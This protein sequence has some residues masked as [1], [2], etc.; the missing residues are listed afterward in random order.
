VVPLAA[1]AALLAI[2]AR[3]SLLRRPYRVLDTALLAWLTVAAAALA[4]LSASLRLAIAPQAA[5]LDRALYI[6]TLAR[7][8]ER[9]TRALS[10]DSDATM[11]AIVM[12]VAILLIFWSAR[13]I[14]GRHGLRATAR[15]LAWT[16]L[17]LSAITLVQHATS[18][19][20]IY[21]YFHP[22][23]RKAAP[24]GPYVNR[25]DLATWLLM[26]IPLVA[27]YGIARVTSR[28]RADGPVDLEESVDATALSLAASVLLMLATVLVS[29]SRSGLTGTVV[30]LAAF[31]WLA[32]RRLGASGWMWVAAILFALLA[33]ATTYA[34][35]GALASRMD[36]TLAV[37]IGG[38]RAV[39]AQTWPMVRD[40]WIS[41][42]GVG[43]FERAMTV[44]QQAPHTFYINHAH[45]EYL[46]LLAE[47]GVLLAVPAALAIGAAGWQA[48]RQLRDDHSPVF[49][50]RAG[51][52]SGMLA[53]AVQGIWDTGLRLPAN[54]VLFALLA[55][56][57]LH[58]GQERRGTALKAS[59]LQNN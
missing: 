44:Y 59:R 15:G 43:A 27:G 56:I 20:L 36:E 5:T 23:A 38:R 22:I 45:N 6:G 33:L 7:P 10:V 40:F 55:A 29:A 3:P 51:A 24:Y 48:I 14:L 11:W 42:V 17:A 32:R 30:G 31:L 12:A 49:W 46:Q 52:A 9:Q 34:N 19:T 28:Q 18:P 57:A 2:A 58:A 47:G 16:G 21:W 13:A 25:N 26:A 1:G 8:L 53:A 35:W 54:A 37:G 39:W 50:I 4:P 41:G